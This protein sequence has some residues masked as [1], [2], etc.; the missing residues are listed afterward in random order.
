MIALLLRQVIIREQACVIYILWLHDFAIGGLEQAGG[1]DELREVRPVFECLHAPARLFAFV[2]RREILLTFAGEGGIGEGVCGRGLYQQVGGFGWV[3]H[4]VL[5][6][7][8]CSREEAF[9]Y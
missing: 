8:R 7:A 5:V 3:G 4:T 6:A 2:I 1:G 9:G